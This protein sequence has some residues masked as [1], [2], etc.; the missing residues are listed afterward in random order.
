MLVGTYCLLRQRCARQEAVTLPRRQLEPDKPAR[1]YYSIAYAQFLRDGKKKFKQIYILEDHVPQSINQPIN[2]SINQ[3]T[4][5]SINRNCLYFK[6][7]L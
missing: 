7:V 3:S 1:Y 2:Q 5:Q 6:T 4:N